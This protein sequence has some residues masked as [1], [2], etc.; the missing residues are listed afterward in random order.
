MSKPAPNT[1]PTPQHPDFLKLIT[2]IGSPIALITALMLYFGWVRSQAQAAA[3]GTDA[4]VFEMSP[5]D[6]IIRTVDVLFYPI[7]LALAACLLFLRIGPLL[8]RGN[9]RT[10]RI[11][12]WSWLLIPLGLVFRAL[13][14][15][16]GN[17]LIPLW[18]LLGIAGT[19]YGVRLKEA[20][21]GTV[22]DRRRTLI[23]AA[24]LTVTLFWQTERLASL[25]GSTRTQHVKD[26]LSACLPPVTLFTENRMNI[27]APGISENRMSTLAPIISQNASPQP[28]PA[29]SYRYEGLY[30]MQ[31]SGNKYFFLTDGWNVNQGRLIVLADTESIRLEFGKPTASC[32]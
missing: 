23:V 4:S 8:K 13:R 20:V 17:T 16:L 3:F 25:V 22:R 11:L 1:S 24:L 15:G 28:E 18:V 12:R 21:E 10:A 9:M 7:I 30:F 32:F 6:L 31:R 19:E 5:D 2:S 26:N 27:V 29:Y 14:P